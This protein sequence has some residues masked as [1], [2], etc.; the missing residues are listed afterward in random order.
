MSVSVYVCL[1]LSAPVHAAFFFKTLV[2]G[3]VSLCI[4][5]SAIMASLHMTGLQAFAEKDWKMLEA[6][7]ASK[8]SV[9][10]SKMLGKGGLSKY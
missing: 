8:H 2:I 6:E 4:L 5:L 10:I 9:T 3:A 7:L 1:C